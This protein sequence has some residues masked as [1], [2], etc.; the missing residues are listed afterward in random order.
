MPFFPNYITAPYYFGDKTFT[1]DAPDLAAYSDIIDIVKQNESFYKKYIIP[2]GHRPDNVSQTFYETPDYHWVLYMI[3][4]N[5]RESGWPLEQ[6]D[7]DRRMLENHPH[8]VMT[9]K[10]NIFTT[11]LIGS[12]VSGSV[13]E[14][15]GTVV[16]RN[17]DLGQIFINTTGT[18]IDGEDITTVIDE[19]EVS[20][21]MDTIEDELEAALYYEDGA[22]NP[23]DIDPTVGPESN[24]KYRY[25]DLY[26]ERNESL[27]T[28]RVIKP[29]SIVRIVEEFKRV[30]V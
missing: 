29:E 26:T 15:T 28:I 8:K 27:R 1:V 25:T 23:V 13:S 16:R 3:N 7:L 19:M 9:T 17:V 4:D 2:R 18:F 21:T 22:G 6:Y 14:A 24:T 12:T 10:D 11:F 5:I 30:M 20:I